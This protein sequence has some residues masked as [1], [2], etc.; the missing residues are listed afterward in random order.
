[1]HWFWGSNDTASVN[2]SNGLV[3][4]ANAKQWD[5]RPKGFNNLTGHTC[6]VRGAGSWRDHDMIRLH[7]LYF[8]QSDLII[9]PY[10]Y[11]SS[12]FPQVLVQVI[13][14]AVVIVD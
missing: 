9:A 3:P 7:G 13:G 5:M 1:M 12:E 11:L 6:L 14:E 8:I 4:Q 10:G 2:L